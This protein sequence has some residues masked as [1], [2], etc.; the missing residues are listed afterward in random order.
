LAAEI[1][2]MPLDAWKKLAAAPVASLLKPRGFRKA[3]LVFSASRPGVVLLIALQS[4]QG[5]TRESLKITCNLGIWVDQLADER[6]SVSVWESHW[7]ERIG[8][9][10]PEP[11][12]YWWTCTDDESATKAGDEITSLL[13]QR[14][15]P[16]MESLASP[17]AL[18]NLWSSGC[19]PGLTEYQRVEYLSKLIASGYVPANRGHAPVI[20]R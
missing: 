7:R 17:T 20:V 19:S 13:K 3:G 4:S 16:E 1:F 6:I 10:L 5:S 11:Q 9:F 18:A 14:A 15:L 8:F 2:F 12:D